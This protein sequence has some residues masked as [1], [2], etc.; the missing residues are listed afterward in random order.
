MFWRCFV[1]AVSKYDSIQN[2]AQILWSKFKVNEKLLAHRL[3]LRFDFHIPIWFV[4]LC[5]MTDRDSRHSLWLSSWL[6]QCDC[7]INSCAYSKLLDYGWLTSSDHCIFLQFCLIA[8]AALQSAVCLP[9][10]N[11]KLN[12]KLHKSS[13]T[14]FENSLRLHLSK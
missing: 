14:F 2:P 4:A 10:K 12:R 5:S 7:L 11:L 1:L 9:Q 6:N 3:W 13:G 8:A